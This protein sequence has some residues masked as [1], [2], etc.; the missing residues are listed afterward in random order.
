MVEGCVVVAVVAEMRRDEA[1]DE[2]QVLIDGVHV[3]AK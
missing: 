2:G 3:F 1:A